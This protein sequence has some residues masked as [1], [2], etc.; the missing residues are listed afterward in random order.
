[1]Q[2]AVTLFESSAAQVRKVLHGAQ[3]RQT[4]C[5]VAQDDFPKLAEE[6]AARAQQYKEA[7]KLCYGQ[8]FLSSGFDG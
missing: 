3:Q 4:A 7:W 6:H 8:F 2:L 1:V 5:H